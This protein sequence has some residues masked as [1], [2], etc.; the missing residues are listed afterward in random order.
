MRAVQPLNQNHPGFDRLTP[1][2]HDRL[3]HLFEKGRHEDML[4]EAEITELTGLQEL[5][6]NGRSIFGK[7]LSWWSRPDLESK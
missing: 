7:P 1:Q 6:L 5:M 2:Q 4:E 3:A